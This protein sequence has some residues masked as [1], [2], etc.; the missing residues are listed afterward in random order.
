LVLFHRCVLIIHVS[1]FEG[2]ETY[3]YHV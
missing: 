1:E 2:G 3:G